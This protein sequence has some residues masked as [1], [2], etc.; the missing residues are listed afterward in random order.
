MAEPAQDLTPDIPLSTAPILGTADVI[1]LAEVAAKRAAKFGG[2]IDSLTNGL[3]ARAS[4]VEQSLIKADFARPDIDAAVAKSVAKARA[5]VTA[6]SSEARWTALRELDAAAASLETTAQLYANPV[7]VLARA[8]IGSAERTNFLT[9]LSGAGPVELRQMALLA[10]STGNVVMGA[11][12]VSIID[13]MPHKDRPFSAAD[14]AERLVGEETRKVQAAVA[15][16]R[17]AAQSAIA[18]NREWETG[19]ASG[20]DRLKLALNNPNRKED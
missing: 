19:K 4:E 11:A 3:T 7:A 16:V 5:E 8:G 17:H 9:Q 20:L 12:I 6:N 1:S 14:L 2:M 10:A 13:R 15:A 18:R